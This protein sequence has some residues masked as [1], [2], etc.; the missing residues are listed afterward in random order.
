MSSGCDCLGLLLLPLPHASMPQ[1]LFCTLMTN[2]IPQVL[3]HHQ[4]APSQPDGHPMYICGHW[5]SGGGGIRFCLIS[6]NN[7]PSSGWDLNSKVFGVITNWKQSGKVHVWIRAYLHICIFAYTHMF[8]HVQLCA[9]YAHICIRAYIR[10]CLYIL[11][12][13]CTAEHYWSCCRDGCKP[14]RRGGFV[15]LILLW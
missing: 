14:V 6:M 9:I 5:G 8:A 11:Q 15:R 7:G 10:A 12:D 2:C 3:R 4:P 1:S 13:N